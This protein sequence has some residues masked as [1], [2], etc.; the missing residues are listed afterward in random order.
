MKKL[1]MIVFAIGVL[2]L[3]ASAGVVRGTAHGTKVVGKT[4]VKYPPIGLAAKVTKKV[5]KAV[6]KV[7]V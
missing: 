4:L 3:P 2:A 1:L 5:V 7:V 6:V